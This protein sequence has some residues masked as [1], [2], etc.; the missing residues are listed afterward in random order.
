MLLPRRGRQLTEPAL[1]GP[2]HRGRLAALAAVVLLVHLWL[3]S[4]FLPARLGEGAADSPPRRLDIRFERILQPSA[5][6][7]APAAPSPPLPRP[8]RVA[9]WPEPAASAPALAEPPTAVA[10]VDQAEPPPPREPA[11]VPLPV[12]PVP[13]PAA[14]AP[15]ATAAA[16]PDA[17]ASAASAGFDW[18]P[19]T[20]L[21]YRVTGNYRGPVDGQAQVEWL[22]SGSH[23]QVMME[24][25]IGPAFAPLVRRKVISDGE[26]TPTG[27]YPKRYDEE[28]RAVLAS[29]RLLTIFLDGD[30][31]RLPG[32][33]ERARPLGVQ[34]SA[35]QFVQLTWLF[36]TQPQLLQPGQSIDI[37][38]ALPRRVETWTYDVLG[39]EVLWTP[40]GP[41]DTVHVKPRRE[42]G[43]GGD[44]TA[45]MW[46]APTLQYLPVRI[47]IRQSAETYLDLNIEKLPEKA[48]ERR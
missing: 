46:V 47:L 27:L 5:P 4:G 8:R 33:I 18:P 43:T 2:R 23:Y 13:E 40:A 10:Q 17:A 14:S 36:T 28:T 7:A 24:I 34:D 19:S 39:P 16:P 20:R 12:T 11:P 45:E 22:R 6:P 48:A 31:V 42:A 32:G 38:L 15:P 44:L 37:P 35:S 9:A 1:A 25:S 30:R 3:A 21:S 26:I 41:V 29:P